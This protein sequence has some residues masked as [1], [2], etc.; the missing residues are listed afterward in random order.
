MQEESVSCRGINGSITLSQDRMT[1]IGVGLGSVRPHEIRFGDVSSIVVQRKSVIPLMTLMM[2][3][4]IALFIARYNLL[5]FA[6]NL[7][8]WQTFITPIALAIAILCAISA[9]L[10]LMFV[11]VTVRSRAGP[12]TVRLVPSRSAKRLARRFRE[13]YAGS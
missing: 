3:A 6:I 9:S 7:Y 13:M 5:W 11:N 8:R 1:I 10:R 4:I 12:V 2:L